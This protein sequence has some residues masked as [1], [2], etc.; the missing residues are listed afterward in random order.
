MVQLGQ[1]DEQDLEVQVAELEG[2]VSDFEV[3]VSELEGQLQIAKEMR[4]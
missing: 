1:G 4:D 2:Q 3:K